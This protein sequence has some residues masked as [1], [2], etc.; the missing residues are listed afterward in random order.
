MQ[1]GKVAHAPDDIHGVLRAVP[2]TGRLTAVRCM[3]AVS[4]CIYALVNRCAQRLVNRTID[5]YL[6]VHSTFKE[7]VS[8]PV[9]EV[10]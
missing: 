9:R 3:H 2:P 4:W 6:H 8:W 7:N 1:L 5:I 10:L